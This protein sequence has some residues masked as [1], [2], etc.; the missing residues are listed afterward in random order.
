LLGLVQVKG[1][2]AARILAD[3]GI[4]E[5]RVRGQVASILGVD[6]TD[7]VRARCVAA[8]CAGWPAFPPEVR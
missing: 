3:V 4:D 6:A 2:L 7:L 5:E 8:A 1:A